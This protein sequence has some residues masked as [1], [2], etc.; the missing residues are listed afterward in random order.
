MPFVKEEEEKKLQHTQQ[1]IQ[2]LSQLLFIIQLHVS[3][4]K[5]ILMKIT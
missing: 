3:T 4:Y 5:V 1:S 2:K